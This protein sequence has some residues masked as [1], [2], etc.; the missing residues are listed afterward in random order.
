MPIVETCDA[1][2]SGRWEEALAFAEELAD[3]VR[4]IAMR[5]FR[6]GFDVAI[7]DDGTPVTAADRSIERTL[8]ALIA[9]RFP[10]HG[11]LGEEF[12]ADVRSSTWIVDPIDGT[13]SFMTG[14]PLFGTLLAL[15]ENGR[16]TIGVIDMPALD[17][18]W[19]GTP[20]GTHLNGRRARSSGHER[21]EGAKLYTTSLD[22]F[23][24]EGL[25]A[26]D[27]VTHRV[28]LRRF[29]GDCYAYG[30]LASGHC[31]LVIEEGLKPYDFMAL[32]RVVEGAGGAIS[33]WQG[34][35][36]DLHSDGRIVAA[37]TR[38]LLREA[39][40]VLQHPDTVHP[41]SFT[42]EKPRDC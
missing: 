23:T 1:S 38:S 40:H 36:L 39:L 7:K 33:D 5:H 32:I 27:R 24:T 17:E 11:I 34:Q 30:L 41:S 35:P 10:E 25:A 13:K 42:L 37:A 4:P 9:E 3:R 22:A 8:R 21:L 2:Q 26:Y 6:C 19:T 29:G 12:G 20:E 28:G 18:R 14:M 15:V 16:P 31:D